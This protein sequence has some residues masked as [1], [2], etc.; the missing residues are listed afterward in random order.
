MRLVDIGAIGAALE[1]V[2]TLGIYFDRRTQGKW[3]VVAAGT[4]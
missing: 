1:L 2:S 3:Y 4:I